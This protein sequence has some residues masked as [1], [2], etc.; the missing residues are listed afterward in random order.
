[1]CC[2]YAT[3]QTD[4]FYAPVCPH[5]PHRCCKGLQLETTQAATAAEKS[6]EVDLYCGMPL[7][8]R[9]HRCRFLMQNDQNCGT[10]GLDRCARSN[11]PEKNI[12]SEEFRPRKPSA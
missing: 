11:L 2:L 1:M 5:V 7:I 3:T 10:A 12:D 8:R 6:T 9:H 4:P